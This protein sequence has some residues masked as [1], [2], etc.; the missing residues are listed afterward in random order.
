VVH[1]YQQGAYTR[2]EVEGGDGN[3]EQD[4]LISPLDVQVE[5]DSRVHDD[6][7]DMVHGDNSDEE[8]VDD[9]GNDG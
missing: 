2:H 7:V 3:T 1:T 4:T 8:V 9:G 6:G 5:E